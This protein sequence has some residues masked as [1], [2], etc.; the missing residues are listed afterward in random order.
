MDISSILAPE[1]IEIHPAKRDKSGLL[2]HFAEVVAATARTDVDALAMA[3]LK[4][5][6]LGSTG[7]GRGVAIPH[8]RM[9]DIA[10]PVAALAIL[11]RP[12][13]FDAIDGQPVD[14]VFLLVMPD[15]DSALAALS[16]VSRLLRQEEITKALRRAQLP[17]EVHRL[18]T[19]GTPSI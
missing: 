2:R 15:N 16:A 18:L 11:E 3:L 4:R 19:H 10:R 8:A 6:E 5:E 13:D 12:I 17:A 14:V 9:P 7:V 1:H